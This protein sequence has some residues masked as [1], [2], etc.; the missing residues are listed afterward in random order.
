MKKIL[1]SFSLFLTLGCSIGIDDKKLLVD[2]LL[3]YVGD[4]TYGSQEDK[5]QLIE[6]LLKVSLYRDKHKEE[7]EKPIL[8]S[9]FKKLYKDSFYEYF[10]QNF[11][12]DE[13]EEAIKLVKNPLFEK[14]IK[15]NRDFDKNYFI[16]SRDEHL[17]KILKGTEYSKINFENIRTICISEICIFDVK[18]IKFNKSKRKFYFYDLND[19]K[20]SFGKSNSIIQWNFTSKDL[21]CMKKFS[22]LLINECYFE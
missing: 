19:K 1:L 14:L 20:Y 21:D 12:K 7:I 13:L 2:D 6:E 10:Y 17:K 9:D 3:F 5:N 18:S 4:L 8:Q 22:K 16:E 11:T 15:A